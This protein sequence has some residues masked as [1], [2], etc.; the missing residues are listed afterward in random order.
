MP[1]LQIL[2]RT[3]P[4]TA[5]VNTS[6]LPETNWKAL[7][8]DLDMTFRMQIVNSVVS[9]DIQINKWDASEDLTPVYMRALDIA[10]A[11]VDLCSFRDGI[12]LTVVLETLV[13]P[14]GTRSE[15]LLQQS[16]LAGLAS[17]LQNKTPPATADQNNFDKVLRH[18]LTNPQLIRA[19]H[20]LTEVLSQTHIS[21][22]ACGRAMEGIRHFIAPGLER[23]KGWAK[24]NETLRI[25]RAY[26]DLITDTSI[27]PRHA[28]PAHISGV[29]CIDICKRAW[30]IMDRFFEYLKRG[31][32]PLPESEFPTLR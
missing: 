31:G 2:G 15:L 14:D 8:L 11:A 20:D 19:L 17:S 9:V 26:L 23:K 16:E 27:G 30:V 28:D 10:R 6:G 3:L 32:H 1:K 7:D 18:V 21:P 22:I 29:I 5:I 25:D 13:G 24:M 4:S 12:G